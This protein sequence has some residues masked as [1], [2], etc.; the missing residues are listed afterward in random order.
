M[1][2]YKKGF[3]LIEVLVVIAIIG[4]LAS[5]IIVSTNGVRSKAR[6]SK[7]VFDTQQITTALEAYYDKNKAYPTFI[8]FGQVLDDGSRTYLSEVP[9]NPEPRVDGDCLDKNFHYEV[10]NNNDTYR[11]TFCLGEDSGRLEKGINVCTNGNCVPG[12]ALT[13]EDSDGN[14]YGTVSIGGQLWMAENMRTKT[15]PDGTCING[16]GTPPCADASVADN[17]LGR[18]CYSNNEAKCTSEG[19]LYKWSAAMDGSTTEGARGICPKGWHV[20]T[21][22]DFATLERFLADPGQSCDPNRTYA[23]P[24]GCLSGGSH[25]RTGGS[26]GFNAQYAGMRTLSG[27]TFFGQY[28]DPAGSSAYLQGSTVREGFPGSYYGRELHSVTND[29]FMYHIGGNYSLSLRCIKDN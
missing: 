18:S 11:L 9:N 21:Q 10:D 29:I 1:F 22:S 16:G 14:K 8:T 25:L 20:P 28:P 23:S 26:T 24:G 17:G 12:G 2:L 13:V 7:R 27:S 19:A 5:I 15:K 6:D 4:I 3:T